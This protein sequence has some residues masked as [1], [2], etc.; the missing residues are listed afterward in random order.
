MGLCL[1]KLSV[2]ALCCMLVCT[3]YRVSV[4]ENDMWYS[5]SDKSKAVGDQRGKNLTLAVLWPGRGSQFAKHEVYW[6]Q[7]W[8]GEVC[9]ANV[10]LWLYLKLY[11]CGH[12]GFLSR[13][14]S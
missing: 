10:H 6:G 13:L 12:R 2:S 9:C 3:W 14:T 5:Q 7:I 11:E 4:H 8:E 1:G